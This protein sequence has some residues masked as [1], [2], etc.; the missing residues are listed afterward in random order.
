MRNG[1]PSR[2]TLVIFSGQFPPGFGPGEDSQP[3]WWG[4][5]SPRCWDFPGIPK[6]RGKLTEERGF[7][8]E[9]PSKLEGIWEK[10]WR[11]LGGNFP[12]LQEIFSPGHSPGFW[13]SGRVPRGNF[14]VRELGGFIWA[15]LKGFQERCLK[16]RFGKGG[17]GFKRAFIVRFTGFNGLKPGRAQWG[18][19][20]SKFS[21]LFGGKPSGFENGP[22]PLD[23]RSGQKPAG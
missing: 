17:K 4:A 13:D 18:P 20:G 2:K 16:K 3:G 8:T 1:K 10:F 5:I 11:I 9:V 7:F 22:G 14:G 19:L 21:P 6:V 23:S 12:G 15:H